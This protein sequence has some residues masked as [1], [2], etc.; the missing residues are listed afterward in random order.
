MGLALLAGV[1]SA[2][3]AVAFSAGLETGRTSIVTTISALYFVVAVVLG[4][5]VL[6]ESVSARE[7]VG[8]GCAVVAVLLLAY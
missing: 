3:A 8:L 4:V 1:A 7:L 5:V 6:G 2:V